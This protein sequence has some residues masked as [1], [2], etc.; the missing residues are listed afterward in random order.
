MRVTNS[1]FISTA[2]P[3]NS[4]DA[5]FRKIVESKLMTFFLACS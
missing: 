2:L 4:S 1:F 5:A 3:Q